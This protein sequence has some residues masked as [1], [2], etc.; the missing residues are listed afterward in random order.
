MA[1]L[2]DFRDERLR[3]LY[4][5]KALGINPYPADSMR[6][7]DIDVIRA[8]FAQLEGQVVTTVGRI[9]SIRKFGKIAFVVIRDDSDNNLQLFIRQDDS[10]AQSDRNMSE[11][12][13]PA[14]HPVS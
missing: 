9:K 5:L 13:V 3:K 11:L 1:T 12:N 6:T 8:D 10:R 4:E 7:H 14:E 2:K